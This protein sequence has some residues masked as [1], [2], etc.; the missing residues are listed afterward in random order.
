MIVSIFFLAIIS[1]SIVNIF[2][3]NLNLYSYGF[4]NLCLIKGRKFQ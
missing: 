3:D 2:L 1:I 4:I